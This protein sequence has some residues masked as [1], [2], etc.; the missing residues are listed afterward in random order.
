M[1][2]QGAT[3]TVTIDKGACLDEYLTD[4]NLYQITGTPY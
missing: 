1:Q 2:E 3:Q 4:E